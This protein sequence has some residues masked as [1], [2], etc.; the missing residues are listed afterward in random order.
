MAPGVRIV[1]TFP[2]GYGYETDSIGMASSHVAL[3]GLLISQEWP[4]REIHPRAFGTAV[5]LGSAG[6]NYY[7]GY[8]RTNAA[9]TIR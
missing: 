1:S 4:N 5:A 3:A 9:W 7:Y 8:Y 2:D 6:R